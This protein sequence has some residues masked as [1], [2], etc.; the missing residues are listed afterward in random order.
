M[1][2]RDRICYYIILT[3][4]GSP[5]QDWISPVLRTK[6]LGF[7]LVC[8]EEPRDRQEYQ[9]W[10]N[11]DRQHWYCHVDALL[12]SLSTNYAGFDQRDDRATDRPTFSGQETEHSRPSQRQCN[13]RDPDDGPWC[14]SW[15]NVRRWCELFW[16]VSRRRSIRSEIRTSLIWSIPDDRIG[17]CGPF[18]ICPFY[19]LIY[20]YT[21]ICCWSFGS[22]TTSSL[23]TRLVSRLL[24]SPLHPHLILACV[25]KHS[26]PLM[27]LLIKV[28]IACTANDKS[29]SD[30]CTTGWHLFTIPSTSK[31]KVVDQCQ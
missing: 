17:D 20:I 9:I 2:W 6:S 7:G 31:K 18:S 21:Y 26:S 10:R 22:E 14:W 3:V 27:L 23:Q 1:E 4:G 19:L 29:S 8:Y 13:P 28:Y 5:T 11:A 12:Y 16:R 30:V 25:F 24:L 15:S